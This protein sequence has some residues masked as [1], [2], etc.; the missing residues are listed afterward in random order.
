MKRI[1]TLFALSLLCLFAPASA[2]ALTGQSY[3]T[4]SSYYQEN[5]TF[6]NESD[7]RHLLPMV[8][9]RSTSDNDD[10]RTYYALE[11]DVLTVNVTVDITGVIDA[12]SIHFSPPA[13]LVYGEGE[14]NDVAISGYHSYA[15]LM[16]MDAS[17]DP[18]KRYELVTAVVEGLKNNNGAYTCQLGAYTLTCT[19]GDGVAELSFANNGLTPKTAA[20]GEA[21]TP[22]QPDGADA[23]EGTSSP[24]DPNWASNVG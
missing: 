1:L 2:F 15:F 9:S 12:C 18:A 10:G 8:L 6:I 24:D 16:A 7:S 19:R 21:D 3:A 17:T 20:P 13:N 23:P 14:Y 4:F 22:A 5:V 11:G